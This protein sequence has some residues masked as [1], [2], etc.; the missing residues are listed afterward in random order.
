M[1]FA[2]LFWLLAGLLMIGSEFLVPGF[3]IFFFGAGAVA[4]GLLTWLIPGLEASFPIQ[5]LLWA[6]SSSVSLALLRK[7]FKP[8][9]TGKLLG[10]NDDDRESIGEIAHVIEPIKPGENGRVRYHGTSWSAMSF[11][12]SFEVGEDVEIMSKDGMT[13]I[14]TRSIL[15]EID[16]DESPGSP[17]DRPTP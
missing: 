10:K 4:T 5:I 17:G 16:T 12:E 9:F 7:Y 13:L 1:G 6:T 8:V 14:V 11:D 3:V 2:P 15:G